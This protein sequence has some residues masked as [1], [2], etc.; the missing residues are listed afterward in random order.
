MSSPQDE[1]GQVSTGKRRRF[2]VDALF[3]DHR[4]Q[5]AGVEDL[6]TA[7]VILLD[8]IIPDPDQPRRTF[9]EDK[10]DE[11]AASIR[12][13]GV[14]QPIVVRYDEL[15]DTYVVIHGERRWRAARLAG[16]DRLPAV[17]REV[18]PERR[19]IQQLMENI[20]RDDLNAVD[21][22]AALRALKA[23]LGDVPWDE[24]AGAVGIRR[25][26]LF[27][28]LGTEKLPE[29]I[30][31]DI[32]SGR[33][34]E[35][36]SRAFQGLPPAAQEALRLAV[37]ED[38]IAPAESERLAKALRWRHLPD[39]PQSIT[40]VVRELRAAS[41]VPDMQEPKQVT[42]AQRRSLE[43]QRGG[44][45]EAL[46]D[47]ELIALLGAISAAAAGG[48]RER[49]VLRHTA[50][51]L[52]APRFDQTRLRNEVL[53]LAKTLSR[54]PE[55]ICHPEDPTYVLL[56]ALHAALTGLL[57]PATDSSRR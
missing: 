21:R 17:V 8:R 52:T 40:A 5:A 13:E 7:K 22:A 12:I 49:D 48:E 28:L 20:V 32:R 33:L 41:T 54:A 47:D 42:G 36:Q 34:S 19:L 14:L 37:V 11:L 18:P 2:S 53:A 26:R 38:G 39:D 9:D 3:T 46:S 43:R 57:S 51:V 16:L 4:P 6:A 56:R 29:Q 15:R 45:P 31:D 27:Q 23:Q 10:L 50:D 24:V 55:A 30:Q 44:G 25:S 1:R 35:K